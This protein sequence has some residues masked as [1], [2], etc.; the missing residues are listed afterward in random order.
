MAFLNTWLDST[1]R[2]CENRKDAEDHSR[3]NAFTASR[4]NAFSAGADLARGRGDSAV[5]GEAVPK[6]IAASLRSNNASAQDMAVL[7]QMNLVSALLH[8]LGRRVRVQ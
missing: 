3:F 1:F 8:W 5:E 4:V 7:H 2:C 6:S